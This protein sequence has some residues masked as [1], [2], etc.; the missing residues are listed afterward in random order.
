MNFIQKTSK[1]LHTNN[2]HKTSYPKRQKNNLNS[3]LIHHL[4]IWRNLIIF[5][6]M[7][8]SRDSIAVLDCARTDNKAILYF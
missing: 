2:L 1:K 5:C 4:E 7:E 3:H 6:K 8:H